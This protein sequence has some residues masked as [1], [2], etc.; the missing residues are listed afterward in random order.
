LLVPELRFDLLWDRLAVTL[1]R[2]P[3]YGAPQ[4]RHRLRAAVS[5]MD[6]GGIAY[7]MMRTGSLR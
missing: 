7:W 4:E 6:V 5:V 3:A 1:S 2:N